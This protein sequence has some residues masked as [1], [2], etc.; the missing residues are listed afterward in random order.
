MLIT[1]HFLT[2]VVIASQV[3]ELAPAALAAVGS[4][5]VLD[6]VPHRDTI[7]GHHLNLANVALILIDGVVAL[8]L[9]WWLVPA[10]LRWYAFIIGAFANLPDVFEVPGLFWPRWNQFPLIKQFHNW[11]TAILQY[12]HEPKGWV[13]GLFPQLIVIG[14]MVYFLLH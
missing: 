12:S 2:G 5:F 7:G 3:P 14:A 10:P 11:H 6:A 13:I 4:H 1:P 9:W 8:G